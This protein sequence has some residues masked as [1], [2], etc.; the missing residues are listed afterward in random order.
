MFLAKYTHHYCRMLT[1]VAS[2]GLANAGKQ[3]RK[4]QARQHDKSKHNKT[5][6]I[7]SISEFQF[8]TNYIEDFKRPVSSFFKCQYLK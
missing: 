1:F 8:K 5:D 4:A 6:K 2:A 7:K 3:A